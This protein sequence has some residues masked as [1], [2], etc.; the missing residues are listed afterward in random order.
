MFVL[1]PVP[2]FFRVTSLFRSVDRPNHQGIDIGRNLI[3]PLP[4]DGAQVVAVADG[5]VSAVVAGHKSMGN[6]VAIDHGDGLVTR[7]MHNRV[8]LVSLGQVIRQGD[9]IAL[10]GNTGAST[11]P[12]LHFEV[13]LH[14]GY[15]NPLV[16]CKT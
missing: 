5:R 12:H 6:M 8:N 4:I 2:G 11:A 10:V 14:G 3:P 9:V 1:W 16:F 13:I 7:Y 15:V